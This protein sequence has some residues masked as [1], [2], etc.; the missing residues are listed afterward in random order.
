MNMQVCEMKYKWGVA[1]RHM[2]TSLSSVIHY[3]PDH[4]KIKCFHHTSI[5]REKL[6]QKANCFPIQH[7]L[8]ASSFISLMKT[9]NV[10]IN[11]E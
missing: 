7:F 6:T 10:D 11:N 2:V 9:S 8:L 3:Q 5:W 1:T 4:A